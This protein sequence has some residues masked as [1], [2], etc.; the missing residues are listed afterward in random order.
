ML[1]M[2]AGDVSLAVTAV[3]GELEDAVFRLGNVSELADAGH[4]LA[5]ALQ[6]E[7]AALTLQLNTTDSTVDHTLSLISG[8][9][10]RIGDAEDS[11]EST[12][13]SLMLELSRTQSELSAMRECALMGMVHDGAQCVPACTRLS[14]CDGAPCSLQTRGTLRYL[15][16]K[17]EICDGNEYT[18]IGAVTTG[19]SPVDPAESCQELKDLGYVTGVYYI[20]SGTQGRTRLCDLSGTTGVNLGGDGTSEQDAT[21]D[22]SKLSKYFGLE[23]GLHWI[24]GDDGQAYELVCDTKT[25]DISL[26]GSSPSFAAESCKAINAVYP[27]RATGTR[28]ITAGLQD[29]FK[30]TCVGDWVELKMSGSDFADNAWMFS[31]SCGNSWTKCGCFNDLENK[32]NNW[33]CGVVSPEPHTLDCQVYFDIGYMSGGVQLSDAQIIALSGRAKNDNDRN[34]N[35]HTLSCDDDSES[36]PDGHWIGVEKTPGSNN[37]VARDCTTGNV[38]CCSRQ[39][40]D[41][42]DTF[43]LPLR[44]CASINTGGGVI[45]YASSST[46]RIRI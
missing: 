42:F 22:C 10:Q 20:G 23:T 14:A 38:N 36:Y 41:N 25:G 31:Y 34:F 4:T 11:L 46:L 7:I 1:S 45:L 15:D 12:D 21:R 44:G 40:V 29:P 3:K 37:F 9:D 33:Q 24:E 16:D 32:R 13:V 39:L 18:S 27:D 30:V 8:L 6:E 19:I 2:E 26:D 43:P 28:W 17:A 35:M 5:R